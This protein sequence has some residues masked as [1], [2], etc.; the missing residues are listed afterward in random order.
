MNKILHKT[1]IYLSPIG[2]VLLLAA[3]PAYGKSLM[4]V[5]SASESCVQLADTP[6]AT[7]VE[8]VSDLYKKV[9]FGQAEGAADEEFYKTVMDCY[10]ASIK[11]LNEI[12]KDSLDYEK[13]KSILRDINPQLLAGAYFYSSADNSAEM[14]KFA[15]AYV[16]THLLPAF[17]GEKFAVDESVY[18]SMIYIAASGSYNNKDYDRAIEYFKAYFS[19]GEATRREQIYMYMGQACLNTERYDLAVSTM[20]E[21][22]KA[23]P[24]NYHLISFGLKASMDGGLGEYIQEFLDKA[25]V[26]K[27]NDEPLLNIQGKL[28]EDNQDYLKA[29]EIYNKLDEINPSNLRT[30]RHIALCY[31]NLGV[32]HFN[33]AIMSDDEKTAKRFKRQSN[34]Y[35]SA[36]S[37]K[38]EEVVAND[39]T[40]TKYLKALA[41]SYGCVNNEEKFNEINERLKALG[42]DP[43]KSMGM[44]PLMSYN[45]NNTLN[46][47]RSGDASGHISVNESG[48]PL[49]SEFAKAAVEKRL[50]DWTRKGEFERPDDYQKRVNDNTIRAEYDKACREAESEYLDRYARKLRIS[51]L[52]LKPYDAA[53]EVYLIESSYGPIY[54]KVPLANNEA[55]LFKSNW[56]GVHFRNPKY[57][58]ANDE[59]KVA[60]LTFVTPTGK[61]YVYDNAEELAY[62]HTTIDVDFEAILN[63]ANGR[64]MAAKSNK[65][66]DNQSQLKVTRQSDVDKDIPVTQTRNASTLALVIANE[67]YSNVPSVESALHD[68]E[69]VAEYL[70]K[71]LGLPQENIMI[72]KDVTL[73]NMLRAVAQVKNTVKSMGE[74]TDLIVYYAGHGMPDEA[75]K[76]A[77]LLPVDGDPMTSESCYSLNKLYNEL[78][79]SGADNVIVFLDAC[80]S[81]ARRGDGM[82]TSARGVAIKP[83]EV[84]PHGNMFILSA[85]S[86]QE[87]A[88]PYTEKNHGLFTYYLLKKLQ[89]TAGNVT[90]KELA[91]DVKT[92]VSRQSTLINQKP[93]TPQ[94]SLS[95]EMKQNYSG[96]KL[97]KD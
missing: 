44:P 82:L 81:G 42:E 25:L 20:R 47:S 19:T 51:D 41:V 7:S 85:T 95:G 26:L 48:A 21:A 89:Q 76:D 57:C 65:Q 54:L 34:D 31:Y 22:V 53:N 3:T 63:Q 64:D 50:A 40:S 30:A 96:K 11:A 90:L 87:T 75:T 74:G 78:G 80:F 84:S 18:P 43:L 55:E 61:S 14:T 97:L 28:H 1:T 32:K 66:T 6:D 35:F 73:G 92:N 29:L 67:N 94:I 36:A 83:K 77:F 39:P 70:Q 9:R 16:D 12:T 93:Q 60:S 13:I 46:Y 37:D 58:I 15:Q 24:E 59:V 68:G 17:S 27:P 8:A 2:V 71:T 33:D 69:V 10:N 38:L 62:A 79:N 56:A 52:T 45:D 23:F 72:R 5:S 4:T 49:Y 88:L 86:G 91:E